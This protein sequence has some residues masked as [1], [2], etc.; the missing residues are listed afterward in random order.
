MWLEVWGGGRGSGTGGIEAALNPGKGRS[1]AEPPRARAV[2][3]LRMQLGTTGRWA[4]GKRGLSMSEG[5][6]LYELNNVSK[7]WPPVTCIEATIPK[8]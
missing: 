3:F 1:C 8:W 2:R 6:H 5:T 7:F 4:S